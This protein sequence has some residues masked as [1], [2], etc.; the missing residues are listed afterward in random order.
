[1]Q[2]P[3]YHPEEAPVE[4][5]PGRPEHALTQDHAD[6]VEE[7]PHQYQVAPDL[8]PEPVPDQAPVEFDISDSEDGDHIEGEG[9][10]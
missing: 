9:T 3:P 7:V 4:D 1:M 5:P 6:R 10:L 8:V 2:A